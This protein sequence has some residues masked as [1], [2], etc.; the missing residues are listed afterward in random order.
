VSFGS[1]IG[2]ANGTTFV[3]QPGIYQVQLS[4]PV[5]FNNYPA[6]VVGFAAFTV[7][8]RVNGNLFSSITAGGPINT[9]PTSPPSTSMTVPVNINEPLQISGANTV[10][11]FDVQFGGT[12]A[13]FNT[14]R[15]IFT[16][17]Q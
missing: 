5:I 17:L 6:N 15:I 3:L 4:V 14:C 7:D 9:N 11:G 1:G 13:V 16:R 8:V 10:V 2:Y 12:S